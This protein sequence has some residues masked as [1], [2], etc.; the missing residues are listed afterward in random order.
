M[1]NLESEADVLKQIEESPKLILQIGADWCRPCTVL[2]LA[3][4]ELEP[5]HSDVK[6]VYLDA[7]L[8]QDFVI[9]EKVMSLPTVIAY[10]ERQKIGTAVGSTKKI[11]VDLLSKFS[12]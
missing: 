10:E 1:I 2:K 9:S 12:A 11:V 6:F 8:A 7:D 5:T 4:K 3:M